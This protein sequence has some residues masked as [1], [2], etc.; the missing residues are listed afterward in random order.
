M[1][2]STAPLVG[3]LSGGADGPPYLAGL[4]VGHEVHEAISFYRRY[5]LSVGVDSVREDAERSR[6]TR[7][8]AL[9]PESVSEA[10]PRPSVD[11]SGE[12]SSPMARQ[13]VTL[14]RAAAPGL[15]L[16]PMYNL[17][18]EHCGCDVEKEEQPQTEANQ[19]PS[20][21]IPAGL[22]AI[23]NSL[24]ALEQQREAQRQA[25]LAE[26]KA[27]AAQAATTAA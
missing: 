26:A 8:L 1:H 7:V 2:L 15:G 25:L 4:L 20:S 9:G 5:R 10:K 24:S 23:G 21:M 27:T 22:F 17:A 19:G 16:F 12:S 11:P 18:L 6:Q 3:E 13:H 14:F